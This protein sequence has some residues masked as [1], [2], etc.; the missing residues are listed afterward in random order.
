MLTDAGGPGRRLWLYHELPLILL[1]D[2]WFCSR[3]AAS[4]AAE[5]R[6]ELI[7]PMALRSTRMRSENGNFSVLI[8]S[9]IS[10]Y[11]CLPSPGQRSFAS[12]TGEL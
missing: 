11:Y 2:Y 3:W 12:G 4:S 9:R 10:P 5:E 8:F 1:I 6:A 7:R